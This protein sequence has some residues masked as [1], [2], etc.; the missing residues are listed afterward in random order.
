MGVRPKAQAQQRDYYATHHSDPRW[1]N[2]LQEEDRDVAS[3]AA[4]PASGTAVRVQIFRHFSFP[5]PHEALK[6]LPCMLDAAAEAAVPALSL[7]TLPLA[8]HPIP[9]GTAG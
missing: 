4:G 9:W 5:P 1:A 2:P 6:C 3:V 7:P 8:P